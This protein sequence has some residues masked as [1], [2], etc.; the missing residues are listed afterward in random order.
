MF[1]KQIFYTLRWFL[2]E[3]AYLYGA[4]GKRLESS[5]QNSHMVAR[6]KNVSPLPWVDIGSV[7]ICERKAGCLLPG[8]PA[9]TFE[10]TGLQLRPWPFCDGC[11]IDDPHPHSRSWFL[12][13]KL[14]FAFIKRLHSTVGHR[15]HIWSGHCSTLMGWSF[16][17]PG[18]FG[19]Q[20]EMTLSTLYIL[21]NT[22]L[23]IFVVNKCHKSPV[24]CILQENRGNREAIRSADT[25]EHP[26]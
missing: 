16:L 21:Y 11:H 10:Q 3:Y 18:E 23:I 19:C 6:E 26:C 15:Q 4:C 5:I 14:P 24:H 9:V 13:H 12:A 7:G 17:C 22:Y 2:R 1:L 20:S 25:F 8:M